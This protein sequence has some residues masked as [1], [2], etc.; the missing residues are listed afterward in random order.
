M[1]INM[2][3]G[4]PLKLDSI[5]ISECNFKRSEEVLRS[6]RLDVNVKRN[7]EELSSD[8]YKITL[9]LFI[10]DDAHQI[11]LGVKCVAYFTTEQNNSALIEKNAIA[12]MFPYVRSYVSTIT[13]QPGM[14]PIV[15]P[16]MNIVAMFQ[17]A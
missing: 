1:E 4:S 10:S 11:E 5:I 15:L 2:R 12:I 16:P 7:I 17:E 8:Q 13:S 9:A 6:S 14:S 3:Y